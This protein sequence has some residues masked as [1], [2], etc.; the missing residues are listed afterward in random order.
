MTRKSTSNTRAGWT[1]GSDLLDLTGKLGVKLRDLRLARGLSL[2]EASD[3]TGVPQPTL[4]RIEN[5]KMAPTIGLLSKIVGGFDAPW[6]AILPE[7][8]IPDTSAGREISFSSG[9]MP[10]LRLGRRKAQALH[11]H[12]PLSSTLRS[13]IMST[14]HKTVK[15]GGGFLSHPHTELCFVLEGVLRIH[16]KGRRTRRLL[17]G[18]SALF[19]AKIPHAYTSESGGSVRFLLVTIPEGVQLP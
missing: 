2:K 11:P 8:I 9:A 14:R 17:Q 1:R 6:S 7:S 15:D 19:E 10:V 5:N 13:F 12:N 4:S 16:F 3:I 18:E